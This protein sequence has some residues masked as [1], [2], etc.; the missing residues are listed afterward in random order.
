MEKN[1]LRRVVVDGFSTQEEAYRYM[2]TI[3]QNNDDISSAW[4]LKL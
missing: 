4:V 2:K 3:K 1:D